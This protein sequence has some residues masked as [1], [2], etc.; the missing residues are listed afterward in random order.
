M[1][2]SVVGGAALRKAA[3]N[4]SPWVRSLTQL[5]LAWTNSPAPIDGRGADHGHQLPLA[6]DL[7]P[8]HA[9]AGLRVV[10]GHPLDQAGQGLALGRHGGG[11]RA[12]RWL[13]VRRRLGR[14]RVAANASSPRTPSSV[15]RYSP[16]PAGSNQP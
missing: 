7:D 12:W 13:T 9:E 2:S 8:Q 6:A 4:C 14:D 1:P 16:R 11:S 15:M 10:E 3:L 5:P